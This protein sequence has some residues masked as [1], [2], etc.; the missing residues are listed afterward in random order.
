MPSFTITGCVAVAL[1]ATALVSSA[2]VPAEVPRIIG[3]HAAPS[4]DFKYITYIEGNNPVFGGS[5]C[6]GSLIAPNV[7]LTAGHCTY[8]TDFTMYK[9]SEIQVGFTH[10]TP[11]PTVI[12]K[13]YSVS[14]V[15][16]HPSFSMRTL[17]NDIAL[18]ILQNSVPDTVATK[19]KIYT[20]T[21]ANGAALTAAGFG[22]TDPYRNTSIASVLMEVDLKLGSPSFCL[23]NSPSFSA[24][25]QLCTDGTAGRD[26]CNG[27]S[28]GPLA[29]AAEGTSDGTALAGLTSFGPINAKNP[30]GLCAQAGIPGY[31]TRIAPYVS[32]I[33]Q[34]AGL[35][36]ASITAGGGPSQPG[37]DS[38]ASSSSKASSA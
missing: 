36:A 26:T 24:A 31:Y 8:V 10:T 5:L 2:A 34:A 17:K 3:G 37:Q 18:L 38:S 6:T 25:N 11:D 4:T 29:I 13:G 33:A 35:D 32:W 22:L 15:I 14:K 16:T 27:D 9:A 12:Y 28:G 21:Y 1:A 20:G 30:D 23:A 7:V 19:A